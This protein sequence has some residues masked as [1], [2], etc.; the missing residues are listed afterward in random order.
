MQTLKYWFVLVVL[1]AAGLACFV[2]AISH[3]FSGLGLLAGAGV[4]VFVALLFSYGL[5][6]RG[7]HSTPIAR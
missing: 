6:M 7:S 5:T 1:A 3:G 2:V 4:L